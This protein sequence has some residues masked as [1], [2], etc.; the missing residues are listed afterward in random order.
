MYIKNKLSSNVE[1][2]DFIKIN[3]NIID[4]GNIITK[5]IRCSI[6]ISSSGESCGFVNK[7]KNFAYGEVQ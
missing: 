2:F 3:L 6:K 4:D 5:F 7:V 1:K